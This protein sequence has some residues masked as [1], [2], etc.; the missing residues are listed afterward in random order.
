[1]EKVEGVARIAVRLGVPVEELVAANRARYPAITKHHRMRIGS[2]LSVPADAPGRLSDPSPA[3]AP[4]PGKGAAARGGRAG[5]KLGGRPGGKVPSGV[6]AASA[7]ATADADPFAAP[8]VPGAAASASAAPAAA[9]GARAARALEPASAARFPAF[10]WA[11]AEDAAPSPN[12][13]AAAFAAAGGLA[14]LPPAAPFRYPNPGAG[15]GA[16]AAA[17]WCDLGVAPWGR[18]AD[19][20]FL[21]AVRPRPPST[22]PSAQSTPAISAP[23]VRIPSS[24]PI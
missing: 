6:Q 2:V 19:R 24:H 12:P 18:G 11:S 4:S 3:A 10:P 23:P 14:P 16:A 22:L 13:V 9:A 7:A 1:M 17:A 21:R 5:G 20:A 8:G 15:S